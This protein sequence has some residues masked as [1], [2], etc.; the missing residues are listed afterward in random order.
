MIKISQNK[1]K[2]IK[3]LAVL[4]LILYSAPI[5]CQIFDNEQ[6]HYKT[7]WKQID[8]PNFKLVFPSTFENS[9]NTLAQEIQHFIA[10]CSRDMKIKP[11]KITYIL[12]SNHVSQNGFVQLA[13]RKSE[14]YPVP[15]S[16]PDNQP[17]LSNLALHESRHVV[18]F[19]KLTGK[20]KGPFFEQLALA[21]FGLNL[22]A[23]YFEGDAVQ[24][25]TLFSPGGR[26]RIPAWEMPLRTNILEHKD[27]NF[28]KYTLG[29]YRD[30][31]PSYYTIGYFINSHLSN[32]HG[33]ESHE[34]I[35][36]EMRT[37]LV[38]PFNFNRALKS[39]SGKNA[40]QN[41]Q[42]TIR[43]LTLKWTA[44]KP[45]NPSSFDLV[46]V[47]KSAYPSDY[48][49]PQTDAENNVYAL[50]KSPTSP[51]K[52]IKIVQGKEETIT[53]TGIQITPYFELKNQK[54]VWDEYRKD[55]RFGKQSYNVIN[56]Y[57]LKTNKYHNLTT[58]TRLYAPT[59]HPT[60]ARIACVSVDLDNRSSLQIYDSENAQLLDSIT[61]EVGIHIQQPKYYNTGAK[62]IAIAVGSA[63]TNLISFDLNKKT[64]EYLLPWSY[65]QLER[66]IFFNEN[67]IFKAHYNGIDNL[68]LLAGKQ[69]LALTHASYGAFNPYVSKDGTLYYNDYRYNGYKAVKTSIKPLEITETTLRTNYLTPTLNALQTADSS[70]KTPYIAESDSTTFVVKDYNS[71]RNSIN[72]H[73]LSI[74][75]TNFESFDNYQPSLYW[76]SN[77]LLN[78]TQ[79]KIGATYEP[80]LGKINYIGEI[81]YQK[82]YPKISL[83]YENQAQAGT[84][85]ASNDQRIAFDWRQHLVTAEIQLPFSSYRKNIVYSYGV[86]LATSYTKRYNVSQPLRNFNDEI[87]FPLSYQAYFN[88]NTMQGEMDLLPKW[89]QNFSITYR[90]LPFEE[91]LS[92]QI[93]SVRSNF[94]FPGIA[95]NHGLQA[96]LSFQQSEGLFEQSYDIPMVAG[97]GHFLSPIVD[98]TL[99]LNYKLPLF[100]PDWSIGSLAYIKRFQGML[101]S[102]HQNLSTN[103]LAPKSFGLGVSADFNVFRYY[104]PDFNVGTKLIYLNDSSVGQ[105]IIPTFS[106][107]YS[108]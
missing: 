107:S 4:F 73:S 55:A 106:F 25:E 74:S 45:Q 27:Y 38:R 54:I 18:Q 17:W 28:H 7:V 10:I 79:L 92:G 76:L 33:H 39:V 51:N 46:E 96:R 65:H 90:H 34:K 102:D 44:E 9:A 40:K 36:S 82:Y 13:P 103:N 41:F 84:A 2:N 16:T 43:D 104:Y 75:G 52:I 70:R 24:M 56:I 29:S 78:T 93:F 57:D 21:L 108:Y 77:D 91:Q 101:F 31:V 53:Y 69:T 1:R 97:W 37:K 94:Y 105:K 26:G 11:K 81:L 61:L 87:A 6:A 71:L 3:H 30:I 19:D 50:K 60:E 12:Q 99:L 83:R 59:L 95:K 63:G 8:Q 98:N 15:S 5:F 64:F 72:F 22:P 68:Y 49:L 20:L 100:Y 67:I 23:W 80:D 62:I 85:V 14:L 89:G 32:Q 86:N 66:P 48:L 42:E 88:K 58:K 35:L 47:E